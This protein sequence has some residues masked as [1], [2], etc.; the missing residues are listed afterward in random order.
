M[1]KRGL[2]PCNI[3]AWSFTSL[4]RASGVLLRG[5][6]W[7]KG[8][9]CIVS[10][11]ARRKYES[12]GWRRI[13]R[14]EEVSWRGGGGAGEEKEQEVRAMVSR[15]N[16]NSVRNLVFHSA[17]HCWKSCSRFF[18]SFLSLSFSFFRSCFL[19][20]CLKMG[21]TWLRRVHRCTWKNLHN[22]LIYGIT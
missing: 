6:S 17:P 11:R 14:G 8:P 19:L 21:R 12:K 15:G 2:F 9:E 4:I 16:E 3:F 1:G 10:V 13:P 20:R 7:E 18:T 22:D 5:K